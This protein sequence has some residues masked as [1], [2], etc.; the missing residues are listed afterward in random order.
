MKIQRELG[1]T[2]GIAINHKCF[3]D[4]YQGLG[5]L[6]EALKNYRISLNYNHK[7]NS[8]IGKIICG[9]NI[10]NVLIKQEKYPQALT[11][12]DTILHLVLEEK[13]KY[14]LSKT[15]NTLGLAQ[16]HSNKL[17]SAK[18]N[19]TAALD[20]A[21]KFNIHSITVQAN[22]NL[23]SLYAKKGEYKKAYSYY[24]KSKE[25]NLKT[26]N[27]KNLLYVG[28]L[29]TKYDK[30]RSENKINYLA[31]KN[32]IA[33]LQITKNRTLWII[34]F[35]FFTLIAVM[36]FSFGKQKGLQNEKRILSLKQD[37]LRSQMNP[38]FMFNALNSIKLYIIENDQLKATYYL[39]KFSKLM[40][41]ILDA[42]AI[43]ETTLAQE[44]KTMELYLSIENIRFSNEIDFSIKTNANL[45]LEEVK[46]PPLVLQPFLENSIWH[47]LSTKEKNKKLMISIDKISSNYLQ[48]DIEDNGIGRKG[49]EKIKAKKS[50]NRTSMGVNL[51]KDRLTN[52]VKQFNNDYSI[53]YK[54]LKDKKNKASGT[55]VSIKLPLS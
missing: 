44:I 25:E 29:I 45:N 28:E 16:L 7:I 43:Q 3:G 15:F 49:A 12:I 13:D 26:L 54:D 40:R 30:E 22:E 14:Y 2:Q 47:G 9:Y 37:A 51:T 18:K 17:Q 34:A 48:I 53:I 55:K 21:K 39:N 20:I 36:V 4:T 8:K 52:F 41:K 19:L 38:H 50:I 6:D 24:R 46:I 5:N 35:S 33:Q 32:Q 23:S 1:H 27:D 31:K 42:S 11:T 10:A